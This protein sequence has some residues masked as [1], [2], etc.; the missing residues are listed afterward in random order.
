MHPVPLVYAMT[1]GEYSMM[2]NGE[3][4]MKDKIKVKLKVIPVVGY[5][6]TDSYELPVKP[7]PN[8]PNM[9]A[10][11]LYPSLGLFEG[12]LMSVGRGTDFPFQVIGHPALPK[13][14]YAFTPKANAGAKEPK[15][16]DQKCNG[17]DFRKFATEFIIPSR[18]VYL[19]WLTGAYKSLNK[20]DFFDENFNYHAG[21]DLLQKQIKEG[22]SDDEI[23]KSWQFGILQYKA[24]R[25]KYL[26][27][28]DFE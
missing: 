23:R 28:K 15:Y 12:T 26:L 9:T 18:R 19:L 11:F 24:V 13:T 16:L 25:K 1:A 5:S 27:Y 8:L 14:G 21:N 20:T 4:W 22:K 2:V 3:G 6:H 10:V 7:S 17:Y